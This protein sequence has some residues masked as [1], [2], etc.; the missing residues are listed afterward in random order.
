MVPSRKPAVASA[1]RGVDLAEKLRR[2]EEGDDY[3]DDEEVMDVGSEEEVDVK[4]MEEKASFDEIVIWGHE[5]VPEDD[6]AFVKGVQEWIG[7]AEAVS[8]TL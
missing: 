1:N 4:I 7:F 8:I 6:D 3:D 2:M 5:S